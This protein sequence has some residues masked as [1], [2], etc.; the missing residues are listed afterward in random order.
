[1]DVKQETCDGDTNIMDINVNI[2]EEDEDCNWEFIYPKQESLSIKEEERELQSV[3]I[4]E[5]AEEKSVS[6]GTHYHTNLRS[7]E[8]CVL[9]D[10]CQDGVVTGLDSSQSRHCSSPEPSINVKSESLQSDTKR[11]EETTSDRTRE[12]RPPPTK[13]SGKRNKYNSCLECGKEFS[14]RS[15]LQVH[16][17]VH[18]GEKPYY[19]NECGKQFSQIGNLQRHTR[20]H[21]GEKPYCCNECGRQFSDRSSF[22]I[23]T[24]IHTG[25]KSYCCV[26]CGQKFYDMSNLKYHT[27]V[28]TGE[29]PYHCNECGKQFSNISNLKN[30][31]RHIFQR[32]LKLLFYMI[33][34]SEAKQT[35]RRVKW[36]R[37]SD[38][39]KLAELEEL[40]QQMEEYD[41]ADKLCIQLDNQVQDALHQRE[42]L[43][44]RPSRQWRLR[45]AGRDLQE[46]SAFLKQNEDEE[47]L[48]LRGCQSA[49]FFFLGVNVDYQVALLWRCRPALQ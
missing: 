37:T 43:M 38:N 29:K 24:R 15:A 35:N 36:T 45:Q 5:E 17:R 31:T 12:N 21:T 23:H 11:T 34:E 14:D 8:E 40:E 10:W 47:C 4:K 2:K 19:C 9:H 3:D 7:V 20:V 42:S 25:E 1:M 39:K 26:E 46:A 32:S 27:R 41:R 44:Q 48:S 13:K 28:H 49:D 6:I 18:T 30:H 22:Q 33:F 16:T